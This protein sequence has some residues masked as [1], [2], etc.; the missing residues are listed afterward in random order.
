MYWFN[1]GVALEDQGRRAEAI[2]AY[3][4]AL[5]RDERLPD[6]HFNLAR[7]Y[8]RSGDAASAQ[9]AVRHWQLYLALRRTA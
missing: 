2:A 1:L 3:R 6:V 5:A 7:L 8:E 4:E 9:A